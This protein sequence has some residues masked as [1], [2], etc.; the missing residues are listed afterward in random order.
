MLD[1]LRPKDRDGKAALAVGL[2]SAV[3]F[4]GFLLVTTH[5][6]Q[7]E[8]AAPISEAQTVDGVDTD[9]MVREISGGRCRLATGPELRAVARA[10]DDDASLEDDRIGYAH[11]AGGTTYIAAEIE[12]AGVEATDLRVVLGYRR[13]TSRMFAVNGTAKGQ[14][15]LNP[16]GTQAG[17]D[18]ALGCL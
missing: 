16:G 2:F 17:V 14:T 12:I 10:L 7:A 8:P 6:D 15:T 18:G 1:R 4:G 11:E 9:Q 3:V 5:S 13:Y